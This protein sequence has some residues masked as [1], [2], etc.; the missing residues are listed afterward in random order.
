MA[1]T[2]GVDPQVL[3]LPTGGGAV[4]GLGTTFSTDLATGAGSYGIPLELPTG[5][6]AVRPK[7]DLTYQSPGG[8]GPFGMGWTLGTLAVVRRTDGGVPTYGDADRFALPGIGELVPMPDG[9]WL[10]EVDSLYWRI[11]RD[12]DGWLVVDRDGIRHELGTTAEGR[13]EEQFAGERRTAAWLLQ[14]TVDPG[15]TEVVYT[16]RPDGIQRVLSTVR[17]GTYEVR[18]DYEQRPDPLLDGRAG[19]LTESTLRCRTVELHTTAAA[20]PSLLRRWALGYDQAPRSGHSLLVSVRLTGHRADG[21]VDA[22]PELRLGYTRPGR[23]ELRPVELVGLP[24]AGPASLADGT[25]ELVDV[26]GDGLPDVL[27]V[28]TAAARVWRNRGGGRWDPPERIVQAPPALTSPGAAF[29]D[30]DGT[31][32]ADLLVLDRPIGGFAPLRPGGGFGPP[33]VWRDAPAAR[34]SDGSARLVDLDGDGVADLLAQPPGRAALQLWFRTDTGWGADP[35]V[36]PAP[37]APPVALSDPRTRLADITGDGLPD[38][39]R[40]RGGRVTF[41][42]YLGH[43][44]WAAER[45]LG[46]LPGAPDQLD[47]A[48]LHL[49]DVDGDGRADCVYV[50]A[51]RVLVWTNR[52]ARGWTGPE[53]VE[54]TPACPPEYVRVVDL[55]GAGVAGVLYALAPA[56]ARQARSY[57]LDLLG[58]RKPYLLTEIDAGLG[59]AATISYRPSTQFAADDRDAG[60]PWRT[61]CPFPVHCVA[62][63]TERD[64]LTAVERR[65]RYRYHEGHWDP[66]GRTFAGFAA[67]DVEELGDATMPTLLVRNRFSVGLDPADPR[68][69]LDAEERLRFGALRHRMVE[70][71]RF[72]PDG[73]PAADRPYQVVR[74]FYDAELLP[75]AAGRRVARP[76]QRR[77]LEE[78]WERAEAPFAFRETTYAAYDV[79]GNVLEQRERAWRAA[80][81]DVMDYDVTT[82][83]TFAR[84]ADTHVLGKPARATETDGGGALLAV[85][86][87]RYDGPAHEGLPEG[88]VTAGFLTRVDR[89]ALPD[90][91]VTE[92]YGAAPPDL[93][94]LGYRRL[95]G[96]SGWWVTETSWARRRGADGRLTLETRSATGGLTVARFDATEQAVVAV[97]DAAGNRRTATLDPRTLQ[98]TAVTEPGGGTARDVFDGLG[99]V[100]ATIRPGDDAALPTATFSYAAA[101]PAAPVPQPPRTGSARRERSGQA[102]TLDQVAYLDSRGRTL[103][104]LAE[105]EGD[106][107]REWVATEVSRY[108]ARGPVAA[109]LQPHYRSGDAWAPPDPAVPA[110]RFRYDPVGRM[111]E[112]LRPGGARVRQEHGPGWVRSQEETTLAGQRHH[113]VTTR[114]DAQRR[115][116]AVE[117]ETSTGTAVTRYRYAARDRLVAVELA[118]GGRV[119]LTSD[120]LG[121]L[122]AQDAPATGRTRFVL[123]AAGNQAGRLLANGG[124]TSTTFDA[125]HRPTAVRVD[126]AAQ[127]SIEWRYLDDG[128]PAPADGERGRR[129]RL[130]QVVDRVGTLTFGYDELGR[131]VQT[132]RGVTELGGHELVTDTDYDALGR[133]VRTVLPA[134]APGGPRREV[135]TVYGPRGLPVSSPGVVRSAEYDAAGRAVRVEYGNRVV[136]TESYDPVTG[137]PTGLRV[138]GPGGT[139]LREHTYA[140]DAGGLLQSVTTPDPGERASYGYDDYGHL[141][142]ADYGDGTHRGYQVDPSG[143]LTSIDGLG[144]LTYADPGTGQVVAAGGE[145]YGYDP[146]GFLVAAPYGELAYNGLDDLVRVTLSDGRVVE[147]VF[148]YRGLRAVR[149]VAGGSTLV[150]ADPHV[151]VRDGTATIWVTFG[152]KRVQAVTGSGVAFLHADVYGSANLFT[153]AAGALL[154]RLLQDPYGQV[155]GVVGPA[156]P[157]SVALVPGGVRYH[158]QPFDVDVGLFMLGRR[159]FDPRIGRFVAPD[160]SVHGVY[161]VDSWNPYCYARGNPV[162][163][164]DASGQFDWGTFFAIVAVVVVVAVLVVAGIATF[165]STWALAGLTISASAVYFG[166]AVGVAAGAILGGI[167][168]A[169]AGGDIWKGIL[170][171]GLIGG[172]SGALGGAAGSAVFLGLGGPSATGLST[173]LAYMTSGALQGAIAG[174][175]TGAAIGYAGGR[176]TAESFWAHVAKGALI[177][178]V[179]GALLGFAGAYLQNNPGIGINIGLGKLDPRTPA[180]GGAAERVDFLDSAATLGANAAG[181]SS[182]RG[183]TSL[184]GLGMPT[185]LSYHIALPAWV[186]SVIN[187]IGVGAATDVLIGL[188]KYDVIRF[189]DVLFLVLES[190]PYFIGVTLTVM[191]TAGWLDWAKNPVRDFFAMPP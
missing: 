115:V 109:Q 172:V 174:A 33:V 128:D 116:V 110:L 160:R 98:V 71:A 102:G 87:H 123:D 130:H 76:R 84:N 54:G 4:R 48:R 120:L 156:G 107:G 34:L 94:G 2:S 177:G 101:D 189:G 162:R 169:K 114:L 23:R 171:G 185:A 164:S 40:V 64:L 175:G 187:T 24:G 142:S 78:Q 118:D 53:V 12:G 27:E 135:R 85:T 32:T 144:P 19:F 88:A 153:D 68:R 25:G 17:W 191:D 49:V 147:Q 39:V 69:A 166:A 92:V 22:A 95:T 61:F 106:A 103:A 159:A 167:A 52:S 90:A 57:F 82:R 83:M 21:S 184:V 38:L 155:R 75:G 181:A 143:D 30:L 59:A 132:R 70:T 190:L 1:E 151:D 58:G 13:V 35:T 170:V 15:G 16:Y 104:V 176:G 150:T 55:L 79:D 62:E 145:S 74:Y 133:E 165:G 141:L 44:R 163:G 139:V 131:I 180:A 9:S 7:L 93:A 138:V 119:M 148:D 65:V 29:A 117:H 26:D 42:P 97:V 73:G 111:V 80:T 28:G 136:S 50:D 157:A 56:G 41:W 122:L 66:A 140:F 46:A 168:A 3:A 182:A 99:R 60:R 47:P 146:A 37:D 67:V 96:E 127:P 36:V 161:G 105:G 112:Q 183:A 31:G 86:V 173:Y 100:T 81:P 91:L 113:V 43:G 158:G 188:D 124:S 178:L 45:D 11:T 89:L 8:Q 186:P 108:A 179:T 20:A 152:N 121:R 154:A 6:N 5:P 126:G 10:P 149:R 18:L 134:P 51:G 129:G 72:G 63:L 14:R 137:Q 77:V 125:L